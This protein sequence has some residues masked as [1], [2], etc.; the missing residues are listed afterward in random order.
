MAHESKEA[1]VLPNIAQNISIKQIDHEIEEA[2]MEKQET[3]HNKATARLR[4]GDDLDIEE[5]LNQRDNLNLGDELNFEDEQ[6]IKEELEIH[7]IH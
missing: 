3:L 2:K 7:S 1:L 5:A 6:N 4:E